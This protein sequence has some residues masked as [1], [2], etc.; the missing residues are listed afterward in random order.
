MAEQ[1][2]RMKKAMEMLDAIE[3]ADAA[4]E[5][6]AV[7]QELA[8]DYTKST[9]GYAFGDVYARTDQLGLRER[10]IATIAMLAAIGT[11]YP[12]LKVH[13]RAGLKV[14]LTKEEIVEVISHVGVYA[15]FP[16]ACN[17]FFAMKESLN[18]QAA[19]AAKRAAE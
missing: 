16:A 19:G 18:E 3:D 9:V 1:D 4:D 14:G 7:L 10:E 17:A 6:V 2:P 12:Q 13:I 5:V 15:G 11:A 8:P